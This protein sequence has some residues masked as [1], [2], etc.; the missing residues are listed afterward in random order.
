MSSSTSRFD[1]ARVHIPEA[2]SPVVRM[3]VAALQL[4]VPVVKSH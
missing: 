1:T 2:Q 3:D 4:H